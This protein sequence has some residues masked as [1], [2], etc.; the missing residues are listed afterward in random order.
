MQRAELQCFPPEGDRR[1]V[2]TGGSPP[3]ARLFTG[4]KPA[5]GFTGSISSFGMLAPKRTPDRPYRGP[6]NITVD[7]PATC[8]NR[9]AIRVGVLQLKTSTPGG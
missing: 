3:L 8:P 2:R 5:V 1:L 7:S 4:N 9:A 6:E